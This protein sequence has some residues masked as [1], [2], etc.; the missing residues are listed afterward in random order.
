MHPLILKD[1]FS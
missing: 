1:I